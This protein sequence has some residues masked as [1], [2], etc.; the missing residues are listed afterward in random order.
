VAMNISE[1]LLLAAWVACMWRT[2]F[3]LNLF[4]MLWRPCVATVLMWALFRVIGAHSLVVLAPV[5]AVA[6]ALYLGILYLLGAFSEAEIAQFREGMRFV[7]PFIEQWTGR[8][9]HPRSQVL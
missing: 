6:F 4:G 9:T 8:T 5:F 7:R 2:G 3:S 1:G